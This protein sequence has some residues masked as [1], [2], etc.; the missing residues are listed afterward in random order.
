MIRVLLSTVWGSMR[1]FVWRWYVT[2][3]L[4]FWSEV[5][6]VMSTLD[7]TLGVGVNA[8]MIT[9]PLFGDYSFIGKIIGPIFRC[10]RVCTG[11][12]VYAVLWCGAGAIWLAWCAIPVYLIVRSIG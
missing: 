9:K 7:R 6:S 3:T 11:G 12:I 10:M 4:D 5:V 8:R 1:N 2:W